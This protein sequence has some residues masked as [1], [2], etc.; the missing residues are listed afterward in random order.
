MTLTI[1]APYFPMQMAFMYS[2][3]HQGM[4]WSKPYS[5][6]RLHSPGWVTT[7]DYA[8]ST[9]VPFASMYVNYVA[10]IEVIIF[11]LYFGR[12]KDAHDM[13]RKYLLALGLGKIFPKLNDE[14]FPSDRPPASLGGLWSCTRSLP[15]FIIPSSTQSSSR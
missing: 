13:Y 12:T 11:Y 9:I 2:N 8:P 5:L 3:I 6:T 4:P 15:T 14:W 1:I 10:V 7:I